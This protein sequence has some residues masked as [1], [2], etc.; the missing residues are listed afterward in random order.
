MQNVGGRL[1]AGCLIPEVAARFGIIQLEHQCR[2]IGG[3]ELFNLGR[4]PKVVPAFLSL[5]VRVLG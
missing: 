2:L 3:E 5:A 4:R 1:P